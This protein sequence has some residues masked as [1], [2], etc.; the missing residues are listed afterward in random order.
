MPGDAK[1][2]RACFALGELMGFFPF[3]GTFLWV[4]F[5]VVVLK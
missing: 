3:L 2:T 1:D 5:F 4:F